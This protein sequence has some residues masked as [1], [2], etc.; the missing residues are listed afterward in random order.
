MEYSSLKKSLKTLKL[1]ENTN[2]TAIDID[3][4]K[5]EKDI[6]GQI[7]V[8]KQ[9]GITMYINKEIKYPI[10]NI[11]FVVNDSEFNIT[12]YPEEKHWKQKPRIK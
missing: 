6:L 12:W 1:N 2:F 4:T 8:K 5:K 9:E 10:D 11:A 7:K 3:Y